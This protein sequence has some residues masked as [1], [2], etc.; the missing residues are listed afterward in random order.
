MN[1]PI[2]DQAP[3]IKVPKLN[4]VPNMDFKTNRIFRKNLSKENVL[5]RLLKSLIKSYLWIWNIW[6]CTSLMK[7]KDKNHHNLHN[8]TANPSRSIIMKTPRHQFKST[9][10]VK[11]LLFQISVTFL[12]KDQRIP[13]HK[14]TSKVNHLIKIISQ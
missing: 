2:Q 8:I 4:K 7:K 3:I 5:T 6:K 1:I 11:N 10:T 12:L 14:I 13:K 9:Y